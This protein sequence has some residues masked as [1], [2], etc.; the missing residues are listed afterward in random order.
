MP[1]ITANE[2]GNKQ[3]S[4]DINCIEACIENRKLWPECLI[5]LSYILNYSLNAANESLLFLMFDNLKASK[6][7]SKLI[8]YCS[9][10]RL[11]QTYSLWLEEPRLHDGNLYLPALPPQYEAMRLNQVF[12]GFMV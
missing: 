10:L 6:M 1:E 5:N 2:S 7:T 12:Q 11:Y 8:F 4:Q 3:M 9:Y